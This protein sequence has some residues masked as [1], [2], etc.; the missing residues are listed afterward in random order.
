MI[1]YST[2]AGS[3]PARSSA[4]RIAIARARSPRSP[5][6]PPSLPNGVRTA[7]TIT[8]GSRRYPAGGA[9][10]AGSWGSCG[11]APPVLSDDASRRIPPISHSPYPPHPA[12]AR[13]DSH[14]RHR[15]DHPLG[16]YLRLRCGE[17]LLESVDGWAGT[18]SSARA[19]GSSVSRRRRRLT[20]RR[21]LPRLRPCARLE[22]TVPL[23]A[24]GPRVSRE[25]LRR[26]RDARPLRPRRRDG[27]G[28][29]GD[30][31]ESAPPARR[32]PDRGQA[33][34]VAPG[35]SGR[36][37]SQERY[38]ERCGPVPRSTSAPATR[39][40]SSPR[41]GP[42]GPRRRRRSSST[43][44]CAASTRRRT[45]SCS[46]STGSRSSAPHPSR[47]S[48]AMTASERLPD[49]RHDTSRRGDAERLLASEKDRAE[50]VMLVDLGRNDLSR[51]CRA[52]TV[53]VDPLRRRAL[54][55][56]QPPRLRGRRAAA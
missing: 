43:A 44:R 49:R 30:P 14:H 21:R 38:E 42:S 48:R 20:S 37:P 27:R 11:S 17:F 4:A 5:R 7:E 28:L 53:R 35:A 36:F 34:Q 50:H 2:S 51:V 10:R 15:P 23:P 41:S 46:S 1:T 18:P 25:P 16:A 3:M 12:R 22:P 55:A 52:G 8:D 6:P 45:C 33:T 29:A 31:D 19:P 54:L 9:D 32:Q 56:R 47:S 26:R 13:H 39:T 24:D 40:R